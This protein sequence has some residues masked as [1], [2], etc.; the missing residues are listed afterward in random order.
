EGKVVL[1]LLFHPPP[2]LT[3]LMD[4]HGGERE[5][6]D[7][8]GPY[9][10]KINGHN[11]HR[12][13]TLLPI[14]AD[15]QL[16]FAQ[17]YIYDTEHEVENRLYALNI[18][19]S[20]GVADN[21][22]RSLVLDLITMLDMHNPLVQSFRMA[23]DRFVQS[24]IQRVTLCLIG[25]RQHI[26]RQYNLPTAFEVAAL[27]PVDGNP[28]ESHDTM[29]IR[30]LVMLKIYIRKVFDKI[31]QRLLESGNEHDH[32]VQHASIRCPWL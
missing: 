27:I 17:L 6:N 14:H 21:N 30:G 2:L 16:R 1:S 4:Y 19:S 29:M 31:L 11:H 20:S 5:I 15:G 26:G 22:L 24:S 7:G 18:T 32:S 28:T 25:T 9:A 13:G 3:E 10:F 8:H 12:I 23:K